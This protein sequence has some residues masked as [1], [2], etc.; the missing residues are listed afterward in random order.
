MQQSSRNQPTSCRNPPTS[1]IHH[2]VFIFLPH[3]KYKTTAGTILQAVT[4][5]TMEV[6]LENESFYCDLRLVFQVW[7][8]QF[9]NQVEKNWGR[10]PHRGS[11]FEQWEHPLEALPPPKSQ[12]QDP[13]ESTVVFLYI[14]LVSESVKRIPNCLKIWMWFHLS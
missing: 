10:Q 11:I 5:T 3:H 1:L 2:S 14:H 6:F 9:G 12:L 7:S 13:W 8:R 4:N